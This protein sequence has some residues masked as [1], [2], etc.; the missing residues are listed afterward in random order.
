MVVRDGHDLDS[1]DWAPDDSDRYLGGVRR[2][3]GPK[4]GLGIWD[5]E[6]LFF[7]KELISYFFVHF[8]HA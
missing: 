3:Q 7:H 4:F 6:K 2:V 8:V 5:T 1:H